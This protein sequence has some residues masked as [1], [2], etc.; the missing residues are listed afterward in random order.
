VADDGAVNEREGTRQ[1]TAAVPLHR[2]RL[3]SQPCA[4]KVDG[5]VL[6]VQVPGVFGSDRPWR[7]PLAGVGVVLPGRVDE[8]AH[9]PRRA[10]VEPVTVAYL[11]AGPPIAAPNL[12]LL[13]ACPE[14]L[15]PITLRCALNGFLPVRASRS[16]AGAWV[17]GVALR[18]EDP[19]RAAAT[20]VGAGAQPV[21]TP[22]RW[23]A[24]RRATST[25]PA[26][27][28]R[29]RAAERLARAGP[30]LSTALL[31]AFVGTAAWARSSQSWW[32]LLPC[33][34]EVGLA[35]VLPGVLRG[36]LWRQESRQESRQGWRR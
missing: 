28:G 21:T 7:L 5:A 9:D 31:V 16:D 8:D 14:R 25:D 15:P 29:A 17:D 4:L 32:A 20:L 18:A 12:V 35:V 2:H 34:V 26:L 6:G 22:A 13:F 27:V 11:T 33:A 30:A 10:F 23:L 24:E 36:G 19:V 3:T 1:D